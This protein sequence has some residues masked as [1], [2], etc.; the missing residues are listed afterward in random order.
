[1][2]DSSDSG[3]SS[4]DL[5]RAVAHAPDVEPP[6]SVPP[7][8]AHFRVQRR[9]GR[10]GMG[11]VYRAVD[12]TLGRLVALKVLPPALED[13]E[14]R[15][16]RLM[17]EA[18]AAAA[19]THP[20]IATVYEVGEAEGRVYIAMELVEGQSVRTRLNDWKLPLKDTLAIALQVAQAL[21]SAHKAGIIHRDLKPDNIMLSDDGR[22]KILD[23]G[24]AKL[25]LVDAM[26]T[27]D[28]GPSD[29]ITHDLAVLGTP[30]YMSPEQARGEEV[31]AA[32]DVFAF[33]VT[34]HE[35]VTGGR[36]FSPTPGRGAA[37]L[38]RGSAFDRSA[39]RP[40][41]PASVESLIERCLMAEPEARIADGAALVRAVEDAVAEVAAWKPTRAVV[42]RHAAGGAI[43]G[44]APTPAEGDAPLRV[45]APGARKTAPP[46]PTA[47]VPRAGGW[48]TWLKSAAFLA[49][50]AAAGVGTAVLLTPRKGGELT[51]ALVASGAPRGRPKAIVVTDLPVPATK[52]PEAAAEYQAGLQAFRDG[53][54]A[55]SFWHFK[56]AAD[57]DPTMAAALLRMSMLTA[58]GDEAPPSHVFVR[59]LGLRGQLTERDQAIA[60]AFAPILLLNRPDRGECVRRL[61]GLAEARPTD[62]EILD[63][64]ALLNAGDPDLQLATAD[65]ALALDAQDARAMATRG[66]ALRSLG[67][68]EDA[69]R[70]LERSAATSASSADGLEGLAAIDAAEGQCSSFEA[71]TRLAAVRTQ[72]PGEEAVAAAVAVG[73]DA[74]M[75]QEAISQQ[76]TALDPPARRLNELRE[77]AQVALVRGD[78]DGAR[79]LASERLGLVSASPSVAAGFSF[80]YYPT[81]QLIEAALESGDEA[82]ARRLARSFVARAP[83]W[84]AGGA[85]SVPG[86][87]RLVWLE[88]LAAGDDPEQVAAFSQRRAEAS[89]ARLA[90]KTDLRIRVWLDDYAIPARDRRDAEQALASLS[91][92][93][94]REMPAIGS[95][96]GDA[97]I[98]TVFAL[99]KRPNDALPYLKRAAA[100]CTIYYG[101]RSHVRAIL[102]LGDSL[103]ATNDAQGACR[104]YAQVLALWGDAKPRSVTAEAARERSVALGCSLEVRR[105]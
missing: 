84:L 52:S 104:A 58:A 63:W 11:I 57:L 54:T 59:A 39:P 87:E 80:H 34:L 77:L 67:R 65:R 95:L 36:P 49:A 62:V 73:R 20:N 17:R 98:G 7:R 31:T 92:L 41:L 38:T 96:M 97:A 70:A 50:A 51:A 82:E 13:D 102:M 18:R 29:T 94:H 15:R 81:E 69:R 86:A 61:T 35:M 22:A 45:T 40:E 68:T 4:D 56:R 89:Q 83:A 24:L 91:H 64:L 1:M 30:A 27:G 66:L 71:R 43:D 5:L 8:F 37:E 72:E 76:F 44:D 42:L 3:T 10:G 12:E 21:A 9:L 28:L 23:F 99:A 101:P 48:M 33:G 46:G 88:R 74:E 78:F 79:K 14:A 19:V 100:A 53:S 60:D 6:R 16:R 25:V 85:E 47:I 55:R 90:K 2:P 105:R 93:A 32:T 103:E 26:G 75:I